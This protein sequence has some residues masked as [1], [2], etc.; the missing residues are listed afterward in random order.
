MLNVRRLFVLVLALPL[1]WWSFLSPA[2]AS[3]SL[4]DQFRATEACEA[5]QSFRKGTNPGNIR[6]TPGQIYPVTAK[7]KENETHYYLNI[8]GA[9]PSSR[10]VSINCGELLLTDPV[11]DRDNKNLTNV[12][13]ISWQPAFCET[14]QDKTECKTQTEERFDASNFTLHGLWP[15]PAY[16]N[17]NNQ[18]RNLDQ[19]GKWDE[20][21]PI[22]LSPTLMTELA[23]K[24]PGVA[25]NLHLHEWYKHG[26]CYSDTP[27]EYYR[28]SLDLL[29]QVNES[30]VRILFVSNIGSNVD[31]D[32][33]RQQFDEAFGNDAGGD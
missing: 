23:V 31:S 21:P 6:L 32:E 29:D 30:D 20:L 18:I 22:N 5:F 13:A 27:E 24:M 2:F 7:N 11:V 26:T 17:V 12:L 10:W 14:H 25:S 1:L 4:N 33:I 8:E 3:I 16:C 28:E 9:N 15:K 19:D